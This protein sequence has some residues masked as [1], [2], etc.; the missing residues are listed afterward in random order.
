MNQRN[1]YIVAAIVFAMVL[2]IVKTRREGLDTPAR[3]MADVE[4]DLAYMKSVGFKDDGT[5]DNATM[6]RLLAEKK[7]LA[8]SSLASSAPPGAVSGLESITSTLRGYM[9]AT[10]DSVSGGCSKPPATPGKDWSGATDIEKKTVN[11]ADECAT[12]CCEN[13]DCK[14]YTYNGVN[15]N[16]FLK[17]G[18]GSLVASISQA[19][20]GT[21]TKVS[22][23]ENILN[24]ASG[25]AKSAADSTV[26]SIW[27][28]LGDATSITSIAAITIGALVVGIMVAVLV[29]RAF[30]GSAGS[31]APAIPAPMLPTKL[32]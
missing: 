31:T 30:F 12:A 16:C 5:S 18:T 8:A 14:M 19:F 4:K 3:T 21:V 13:A 28:T 6:Q 22:P 15:K 9:T 11:S 32:V 25:A 10:V 26:A 2:Y 23:G 20:A 29:Y 1:L 24:N 7:T 27:S 17:K